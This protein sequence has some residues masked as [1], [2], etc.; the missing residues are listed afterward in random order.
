MAHTARFAGH[1]DGLPMNHTYLE[2]L[3][4]ADVYE[5][6]AAAATSHVLQCR[7]MAWWAMQVAR[8]SFLV[9]TDT[10]FLVALAIILLFEAAFAGLMLALTN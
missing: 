2:L 3:A 4:E 10:G 8:D 5:G 9:F 1:R 7:L 6:M